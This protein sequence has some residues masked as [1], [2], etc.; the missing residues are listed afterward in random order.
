ML[1]LHL[2]ARDNGD[3]TSAKKPAP[4]S[5]SLLTERWKVINTV[6]D[7]I[8]EGDLVLRCGNDFISESLSDFSQ[9]GKTLFA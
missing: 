7:S 5:D 3:S 8:R 6:K 1:L 2:H 9:A 4:L